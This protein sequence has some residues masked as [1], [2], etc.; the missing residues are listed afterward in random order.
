MIAVPYS[1]KTFSL[2]LSPKINSNSQPLFTSQIA[3]W[4]RKIRLSIHNQQIKFE[5]D[6]T[7]NVLYIL[8]SI[9]ISYTVLRGVQL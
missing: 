4:Q 8:T 2:F 6:T 3:R 1:E 7:I 5:L 9:H